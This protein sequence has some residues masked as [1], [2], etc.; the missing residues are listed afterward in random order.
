VDAVTPRADRRR[1]DRSG[2]D[3]AGWRTDAVLR[4]GLLVRVV[5]IG[6]YGVLVE[7]PNRLRPGGTAELQLVSA[8]NDRRQIV[9]GRIERCHVVR[10]QPLRFCGAIAFAGALYP[11]DCNG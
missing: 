7:C 4:P 9:A 5:N 11:P 8:A 1:A 10:L 3:R 6:P 2:P